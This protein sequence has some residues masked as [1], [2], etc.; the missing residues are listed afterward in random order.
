MLLLLQQS[1]DDAVNR[2]THYIQ[3]QPQ[4]HNNASTE[5]GHNN[6]HNGENNNNYNKYHQNFNNFNNQNKYAPRPRPPMQPYYPPPHNNPQ[7][8]P[9]QVPPYG[10][11]PP[12]SLPPQSLQPPPPHSQLTPAN[13]PFP[14][15]PGHPFV[16]DKVFVGINDPKPG[17]QLKQK[18]LG[19]NNSFIL[20]IQKTTGATVILRG[21]GSGHIEQVSG[22]EAWE[23]LMLFIS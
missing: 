5:H 14:S 18:I 1:L 4:S 11:P 12:P 23:P 6:S 9:H 2:L 21:R 17:F 22:R 16:Q 13:P 3:S 20:H 8:P 19:P 7:Y 15:A 10:F